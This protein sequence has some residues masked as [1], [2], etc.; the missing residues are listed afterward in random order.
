MY[1]KYTSFEM[2]SNT[3]DALYMGCEMNCRLNMLINVPSEQSVA[4]LC[5]SHLYPQNL[6]LTFDMFKHSK[7]EN[8]KDLH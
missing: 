6:V 8:F 7:R 4:A 5:F 3:H 1:F 2:P